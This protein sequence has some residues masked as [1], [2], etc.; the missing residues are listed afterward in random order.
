MTE[1]PRVRAFC[2][3]RPSQLEACR[4][5]AAESGGE[6]VCEFFDQESGAKDDR[7][8]WTAL[9]Q[10]AREKATRRFDAVVGARRGRPARAPMQR[11]CA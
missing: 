8:G 9:T 2:L 10:E 4:R 6:V 7:P 5:K 11:T 1:G 3:S